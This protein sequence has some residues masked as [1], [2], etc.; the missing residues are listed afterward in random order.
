MILLVLADYAF[1]LAPIQNFFLLLL[2]LQIISKTRW[3]G[4]RPIGRTM[5][6]QNDGEHISMPPVEFELMIPMLKRSKTVR[7]LNLVA[8]VAFHN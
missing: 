4:I 1:G 5:Q 6:T 8:T 3:M 7:A 2:I